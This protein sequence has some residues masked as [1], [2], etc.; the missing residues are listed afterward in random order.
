M[1]KLRIGK[2]N[3]F[4]P[5]SGVLLAFLAI[6]VGVPGWQGKNNVAFSSHGFDTLVVLKWDCA[7]LPP[8]FPRASLLTCAVTQ[9]LSPL[10]GL[11]PQL[12]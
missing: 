7:F 2:T 8:P 12:G 3:R 1:F 9:Q 10:V 6:F 5:A 11:A 4:G